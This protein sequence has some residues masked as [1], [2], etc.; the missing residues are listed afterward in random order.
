MNPEMIM[1]TIGLESLKRSLS[2]SKNPCSSTSCELMS[3]SLATETAAVLRT[4]G[5]SSFKHLRSGSHK[6]SVICK[7]IKRVKKWF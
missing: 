2:E 4:Y 3:C 5:S 1:I 7:E 6:Y